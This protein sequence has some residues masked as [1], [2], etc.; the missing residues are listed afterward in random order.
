MERKKLFF[1]LFPLNFHCSIKIKIQSD[2]TNVTELTGLNPVCVK[3]S[4]LPARW[5]QLKLHLRL[6]LL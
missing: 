5:T 3:K 6:L 2:R 1:A 4:E